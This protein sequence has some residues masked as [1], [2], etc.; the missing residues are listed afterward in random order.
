MGEIARSIGARLRAAREAKGL[1]QTQLG[2]PYFT[3]GHVSAIEL[4]KTS[5]AIK[6]LVHFARKL[7]V[8]V[9]D[10]IPEDL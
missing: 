1:S 7:D 10:L 2:A 9:R 6:S 8:P 3:R 5:P 4:G